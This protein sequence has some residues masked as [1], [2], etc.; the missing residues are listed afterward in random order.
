MNIQRNESTVFSIYQRHPPPICPADCPSNGLAW[1]KDTGD[2]QIVRWKLFA[3]RAEREKSSE[4]IRYE[5][6]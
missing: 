3:R 5:S 4:M 2:R 1:Q 6:N